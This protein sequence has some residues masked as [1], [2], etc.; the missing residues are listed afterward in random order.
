MEFLEAAVHHVL[1]ARGLYP[2]ELF[3]TRAVFGA[4][5]Q[6][7]RHPDLEAYIEGAVHALRAPIGRGD[8]KRVVLVIKDGDAGGTGSPVERFTFDFLLNDAYL[9]NAGKVTRRDIE[10]LTRRFAECISKITFLDGIL[11]PLPSG[12]SGCTFEIVAYA[13]R[14]GLS[15]ELGSEAWS[16]ERV[17]GTTGGAQLTGGGGGRGGGGRGTGHFEPSLEFSRDCPRAVYAV[18]SWQTNLINL[19]MF[20]EKR[21]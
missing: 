1:H 10:A 18:K 12:A 15:Q 17:G 2:K 9:R 6:K 20:V 8:V 7:A 19:D 5:A 4:R 14:E 11:P 13:T 16:E 3:E 21:G